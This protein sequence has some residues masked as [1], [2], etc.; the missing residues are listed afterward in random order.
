MKCAG[1]IRA[2]PIP[3]SVIPAKAGI[4]F[5]SPRRTIFVLSVKK[6][7]DDFKHERFTNLTG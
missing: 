3:A 4:C 5:Y 2:D 6:I 1:S 7:C